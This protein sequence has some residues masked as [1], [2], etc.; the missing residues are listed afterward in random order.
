MNLFTNNPFGTKRF[1]EDIKNEAFLRAE[2]VPAVINGDYGYGLERKINLESAGYDNN[3][4]QRLVNDLVIRI[5][6]GTE[7][8]A[9][10]TRKRKIKML[11]QRREKAISGYMSKMINPCEDENDEDLWY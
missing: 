4:V 8:F 7:K 5:D 11:K 6:K 2:V 1:T 9:K 3:V 10:S